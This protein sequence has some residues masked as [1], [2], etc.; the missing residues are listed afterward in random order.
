MKVRAG[1]SV[2]AVAGEMKRQQLCVGKKEESHCLVWEVSLHVIY[3][4]SYPF[5]PP[6]DADYI[7]IIEDAREVGFSSI[8]CTGH[9]SELD[10]CKVGNITSYNCTEVGVAKCFSG[11]NATQSS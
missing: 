11:K 4:D 6:L 9:E 8:N 2:E 3:S 1:Y 10:E 7:E 5:Y